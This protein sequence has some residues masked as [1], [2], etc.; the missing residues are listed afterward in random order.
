VY[1]ADQM[2]TLTPADFTG[3][4]DCASAPDRFYCPVVDRETDFR[5]GPGYLGVY[6]KVRRDFITGVF[7]GSITITDHSVMRLE[8]EFT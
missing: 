3:T 7:P 6:V 5:A 2:A 4:V 8:P 1:T